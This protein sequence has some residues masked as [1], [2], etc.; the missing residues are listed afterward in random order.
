[1][2]GTYPKLMVAGFKNNFVCGKLFAKVNFHPVHVHLIVAKIFPGCKILGFVS[3]QNLQHSYQ[4]S[5]I[6][7][8]GLSS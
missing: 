8:C 5:N 1:M 7:I 2:Y 4:L 6:F 3:R